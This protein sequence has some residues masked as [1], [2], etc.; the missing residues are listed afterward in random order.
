MA[1]T[2]NNKRVSHTKTGRQGTCKGPSQSHRDWYNILWDG[3]STCYRY[4][5]DEFKVLQDQEESHG[6]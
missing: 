2:L 6:S 1:Q 5:K 4:T 3:E